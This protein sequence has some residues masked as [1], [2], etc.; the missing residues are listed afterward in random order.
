MYYKLNTLY[1]SYGT[2]TI[3]TEMVCLVCNAQHSY[4]GHIHTHTRIIK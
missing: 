3:T 1:D 4:K 2:P